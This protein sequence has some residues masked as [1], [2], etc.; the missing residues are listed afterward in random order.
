LFRRTLIEPVALPR[1]KAK[2]SEPKNREGEEVEGR[3][4]TGK[5][6]RKNGMASEEAWYETRTPERGDACENEMH[7]IGREQADQ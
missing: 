5:R 3:S 4:K 2:R 7:C 6:Y 1:R